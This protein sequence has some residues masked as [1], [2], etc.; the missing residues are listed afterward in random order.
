[1]EEGRPCWGAEASIR[2]CCGGCDGG[3]AWPGL[4]WPGLAW[5]GLVWPGLACPGLGCAALPCEAEPGIQTATPH[6][7]EAGTRAVPPHH[8]EA[9]F[10]SSPSSSPLPTP[11][12]LLLPSSSAV[13]TRLPAS[14]VKAL[15]RVDAHCQPC[16]PHQKHACQHNAFV[17][18]SRA[19]QSARL[20]CR[21]RLKVCVGNRCES[22]TCHPHHASMV[23]IRCGL[24]KAATATHL[25][26]PGSNSNAPAYAVRKITGNDHKDS[27]VSPQ[28]F[29]QT[30]RDASSIADLSSCRHLT[31]ALAA[32]CGSRQP[33]C[34]RASAGIARRCC[35]GSAGHGRAL[36]KAWGSKRAG[37][38]RVGRQSL[39]SQC[40]VWHSRT[41]KI[42]LS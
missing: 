12:A 9:G 22:A 8:T 20:S 29:K 15:A 1:M 3:L 14:L 4:A 36:K 35:R 17:P 30:S 2:A 31:S 34:G 25:H 18:H 6:Q 26:W 13:P 37:S 21:W 33:P 27:F 23:W 42:R 28:A 38:P 24:V 11:Y 41:L 32:A 10:A 40:T 39:N 16:H 7:A 19:V 5:H